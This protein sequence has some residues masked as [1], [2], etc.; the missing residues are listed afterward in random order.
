[1]SKK[2][3]TTFI[4]LA[5]IVGI[6]LGIIGNYLL[7]TIPFV[8]PFLAGTYMPDGAS[9][10]PIPFYLEKDG[11]CRSQNFEQATWERQGNIVRI[12]AVNTTIPDWGDGEPVIQKL[13]FILHI[14][15]DGLLYN[16]CLYTRVE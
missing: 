15:D 3:A 6:L 11:S 16:D 8:D 4:V 5:L 7:M 13:E 2:K 14:V 1:M 10:E 12:S 9:R